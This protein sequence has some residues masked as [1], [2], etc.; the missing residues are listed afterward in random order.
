MRW[1]LVAVRIV[2][3]LA[4]TFIIFSIVIGFGPS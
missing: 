4:I 3:A 2:I 1:K